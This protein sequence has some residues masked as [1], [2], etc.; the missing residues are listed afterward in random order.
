M[1]LTFQ[2]QNDLVAKSLATRKDNGILSTFKYSRK[3]MYDYLWDKH[4]ELLECRGHTYDNTNGKLVVAAPRKTFNYLENG[5]WVNVSLDTPVSA[6]KKYNGFMACLTNYNGEIIVSTTGTT[7]SDYAK[8]ARQRIFETYPNDVAPCG[9]T[10]LFEVCDESDP[11]IV[12]DKGTHYLGRR[13]E[14]GKFTPSLETL[15]D[16]CKLADIL[17][18]C[19]TDRGEGFMVYDLQGSCCKIKTE[20]YIGKKKLM[21]M[22]KSKVNMIWENPNKVQASL[23]KYWS[24]VVDYILSTQSIFEWE[25]MTDQQRRVELEKFV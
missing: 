25:E 7:S 6:Y 19:K 2:Q 12:D 1:F 14:T 18:L 13:E 16:N 24:G 5:T 10:W 23:P 8:L 3:V 4:P 21:R 17:E 11:H 20:Y 9:V 15:Q 22:L